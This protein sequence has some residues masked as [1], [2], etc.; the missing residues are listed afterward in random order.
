MHKEI[1]LLSRHPRANQA[2]SL[3]GRDMGWR[4]YILYRYCLVIF[5]KKSQRFESKSSRGEA[6]LR[7]IASQLTTLHSQITY[8]R[9]SPL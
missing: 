9:S 1:K 4:A 3:L 7:K 8:E 2:R 6:T 5:R